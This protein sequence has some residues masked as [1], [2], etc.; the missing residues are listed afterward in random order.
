MLHL[1]GSRVHLDL[2]SALDVHAVS[3]SVHKPGNPSLVEGRDR[4]GR[5]VM[6]GLDQHG[7]LV[8][9]SPEDV[10]A[11]AT[12]AVKATGGRGFLLAPGCSVPPGA[13]EPNLLA[14]TEGAS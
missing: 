1:C 3:W 13:P 6:G 10:I 11:E 7:T 8:Q 12:A 5:A 2:S 14:M 9:S 4:S